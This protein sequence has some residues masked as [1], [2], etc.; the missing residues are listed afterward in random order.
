MFSKYIEGCQALGYVLQVRDSY[1][2]VSLPGGVTGTVSADEISDYFYQ[3][4]HSSKD[5]DARVSHSICH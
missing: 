2:L 3:I 4:I 1:I 5:K